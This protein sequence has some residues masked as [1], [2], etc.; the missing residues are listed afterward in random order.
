MNPSIYT[1]DIAERYLAMI[2]G[3]APSGPEMWDVLANEC[4]ALP[5]DLDLG[6]CPRIYSVGEMIIMVC[7]PVN[8]P[9]FVCVWSFLEV[10]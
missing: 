6:Q 5:D 4:E 2:D 3:I 7:R 1:G 9:Y 8:A 10:G